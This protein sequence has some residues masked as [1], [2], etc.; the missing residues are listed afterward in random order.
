MARRTQLDKYY[1][2]AKKD[3]F[4]ARSVYKLEE[5]DRRYRLLKRGQTILDL[6]CHPG[7]WLQFA[8]Q[9]AGPGGLVVGVDIQPLGVELPANARFLQADITGLTPEE[10]KEFAPGYDLVISDAAPRTTGVMHADIAAS[11]E[12]ARVALD[13]ALNLLKPGGSFLAKIFQGPGADELIRDVKRS[14]KLGKAHKPPASRSGS[15]E[16][17]L[18]GQGKKSD[19]A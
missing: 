2:Q 18:L 5:I 3:G 19:P 14:F 7:S 10:L 11:L 13:L 17:Y 8:S 15:K 16:I 12:L 1:R 6:G 9:K 4:A